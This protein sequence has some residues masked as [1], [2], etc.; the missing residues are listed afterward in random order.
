MKIVLKRMKVAKVRNWILNSL[1]G[2]FIKWFGHKYAI[3]ISDK[4]DSLANTFHLIVD[5]VNSHLLTLISPDNRN[6]SSFPNEVIKFCE[7]KFFFEFLQKIQE[8]KTLKMT[9]Y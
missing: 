1:N 2:E 6:D 4:D 5:Q 7:T 8:T 3:F 9:I